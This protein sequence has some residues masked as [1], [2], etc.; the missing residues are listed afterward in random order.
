ML[1]YR[2]VVD[3]FRSASDKHSSKLHLAEQAFWPPQWNLRTER[4]FLDIF[5]SVHTVTLLGD[6]QN[7][8][9]GGIELVLS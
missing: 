8:L 4:I 1:C 3:W 2:V 9:G 5:N 7:F 6:L